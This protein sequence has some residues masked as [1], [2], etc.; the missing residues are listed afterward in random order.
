MCQVQ[1]QISISRDMICC[2]VEAMMSH[3]RRATNNLTTVIQAVRVKQGLLAGDVLISS[4]QVRQER[5]PF[6]Y[7]N[8]QRGH[9]AEFST[10][11]MTFALIVSGLINKVWPNE[12]R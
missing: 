4:L 1:M 10:V 6:T 8:Y 2:F 9:T 11:S 12:V 3:V 5:E 7:V